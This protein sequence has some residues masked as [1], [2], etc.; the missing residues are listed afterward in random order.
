MIKAT[1]KQAC[2][3]VK[4]VGSDR[5][6]L[7]ATKEDDKSICGHGIDMGQIGGK[8][9]DTRCTTDFGSAGA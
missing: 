7:D 9:H 8:H 6:D 1:S 3:S 2:A 4:H 5:L